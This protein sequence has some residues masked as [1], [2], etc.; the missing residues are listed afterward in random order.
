MADQAPLYFKKVL[1]G[2]RPSNRAATEA[3]ASLDDSEVRVRITRTRGN[4]RRNGLYWAV[5]GVACPM[6]DEKAP[7]LTVDLLHRVLKDRYGLYKEIAL[8]SGQVVRDYDSI[9]FTKMTEPE[10]A[11]FIDWALKTLASWLG[12]SPDELRQEG[13]AA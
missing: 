1:G 9:S 6:L 13:Q 4:V 7:G 3:I 2:L 12:C 8:P 10:R 11:K 5:L